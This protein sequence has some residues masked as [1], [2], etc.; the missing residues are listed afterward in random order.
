MA[1]QRL[2]DLLEQLRGEEGSSQRDLADRSDLPA[3]SISYYE[4]NRRIPPLQALARILRS[5]DGRLVIE[6]EDSSWQIVPGPED[7][8]APRVEPV[9]GTASLLDGLDPEERRDILEFLENRRRHS[10]G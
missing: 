6:R 10:G 3:P 5:L 7:E 1:G 9:E 8:E 2:G 4:N